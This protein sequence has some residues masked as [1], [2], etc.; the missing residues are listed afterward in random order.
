MVTN[1]YH[2]ISTPTNTTRAKQLHGKTFWTRGVFLSFWI[3]ATT[4]LISI[5]ALAKVCHPENLTTQK[6]KNSPKMQNIYAKINV[7]KKTHNINMLKTQ[8]DNKPERNH[9]STKTRSDFFLHVTCTKGTSWAAINQNTIHLWV[10]FPFIKIAF[11]FNIHI[12]NL[13]KFHINI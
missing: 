1:N 3:S 13:N 9:W 10:W 12:C 5:P 11:V 4:P 6:Q 8:V 2:R 7:D